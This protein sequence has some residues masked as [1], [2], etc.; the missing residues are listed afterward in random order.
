MQEINRSV[1]NSRGKDEKRMKVGWRARGEE[2]WCQYI[3]LRSCR[4]APDS[5]R[6]IVKSFGP[7]RNE[8]ICSRLHRDPRKPL[9]NVSRE[10]KAAENEHGFCYAEKSGGVICGVWTTFEDLL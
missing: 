9:L 4:I 2:S 5:A 6:G 7:Q 8:Q 3:G 1:R 10:R